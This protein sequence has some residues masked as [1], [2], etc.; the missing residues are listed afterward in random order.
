[1]LFISC[2]V[3][4]ENLRRNFVSKNVHFLSESINGPGRRN[5]KYFP[6]F[7]A[8]ISSGVKSE[9][10]NLQII[11]PIRLRSRGCIFAYAYC[12]AYPSFH[13]SPGRGYSVQP[14][15]S[16][17]AESRE[18]RPILRAA[19]PFLRPSAKASLW[20]SVRGRPWRFFLAPT[21]SAT[22]PNNSTG[23]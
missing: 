7:L 15:V 16:S 4:I 11:S 8:L 20:A 2:K 1:M 19:I 5:Q 9:F 10:A 13:L 21:A 12:F 22:W 17:G 6:L 14:G 18:P 23:K 3:V